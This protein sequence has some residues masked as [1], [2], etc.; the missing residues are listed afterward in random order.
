M[1]P[2][3]PE[4]PAGPTGPAGVSGLQ[5]VSAVSAATSSDKSFSAS[6]P[7][8]KF[9]VGGGGT[10]S[11]NGVS[12]VAIDQ[13]EPTTISAGKASAWTVRGSEV[14]MEGDNWTITVWVVCATA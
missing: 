14:D 11:A 4:G 10:V 8:G 2:Q 9:A 13:S 12:N 7:S 3:G 6:C 1:G 5:V